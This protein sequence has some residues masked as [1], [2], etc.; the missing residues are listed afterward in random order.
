[1]VKKTFKPEQIINKL[2]DK[3]MKNTGMVE[4]EVVLYLELP[5]HVSEY[6]NL[7]IR[8]LRSKF[9]YWW[10]RG[11]VELPVQRQPLRIYYKLSQNFNL[12]L[13]SSTD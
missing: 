7:N 10:R 8:Q 6:K 4:T 11:R 13:P 12:I 2:S 9:E 3:C 5:V 1:M